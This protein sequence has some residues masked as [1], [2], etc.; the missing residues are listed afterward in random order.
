MF[1]YHIIKWSWQSLLVAEAPQL[2]MYLIFALHSCIRSTK[3]G[4]DTLQTVFKKITWSF[5]ALFSGKGPV[6]DWDGEP[7]RDAKAVYQ[8]CMWGVLVAG[9]EIGTALTSCE[10]IMM[11]AHK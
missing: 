9:I 11:H 8:L 1:S 3:D 10:S 5:N 6:E 4:A 7:I 2:C